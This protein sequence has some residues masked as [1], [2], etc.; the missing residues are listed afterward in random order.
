MNR[1]KAQ[2]RRELLAARAAIPEGERRQRSLAMVENVRSLPC[3]RSS[4]SV[5][6]YLPIG[7]EAN[8]LP[9]LGSDAESGRALFVPA[10]DRPEE[11]LRWR[12]WSSGSESGNRPRIGAGS[13]EYPVI[14]IVPGV[15]FD[16]HGSRLGRGRGFYDRALAELRRAGTT[17]AV[18][19]A[20]ECQIVRSLPCDPW[21]QCVDFVVSEERVIAAESSA[22]RQRED[23]GCS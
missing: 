22:H 17:H 16:D 6:A 11:E 18:G 2:W 21:D 9:L 14:A 10:D 20:F 8:A 4:R 13:L 5:L 23:P 1:T 3:F 12:V 19:L 15:G 7:A